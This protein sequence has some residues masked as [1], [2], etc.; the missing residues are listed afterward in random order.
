[1]TGALAKD[2]GA[3][4]ARVVAAIVAAGVFAF[5]A[6]FVLSAYAPELRQGNDGG[7]HALSKS[8]VGF[9][10]IVR[11][12]EAD[13]VPVEISRVRASATAEGAIALV[14]ITLTPNGERGAVRAIR[15][16]RPMALVVLPKWS[17]QPHPRKPGWVW[18]SGLLPDSVVQKALGNATGSENLVIQR[19]ADRS[20]YVLLPHKKFVPGPLHSGPIRSPQTISGPDIHPFLV[21]AS[22]G[23]ILGFSRRAGCYILADPDLLN[24]Q[25]VRDLNTARTAVTILERLRVRPLPIKFDV[26]LH[27]LAGGR[28]LLKLAFSPPFLA[29]TL[30]AAAAAALAGWQAAMRWGPR[31]EPGR[32]VA[33]GKRALADNA[34][35]LIRLS[36]REHRM[37][38]RYAVVTEAALAREAAA[39]AGEPA[40]AWLDGL[41]RRRPELPLWSALRAEAR[42]ART[43]EALLATAKR[44]HEWRA[45][46]GR[47]H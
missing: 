38:D 8:A 22:G 9:A 42:A 24:T 12:L 31:A 3:F 7:A 23:V 40:A 18:R 27:G 29:V 16:K 36:G 26:T 20:S 10:G 19:G 15:N 30:C 4:S 1:M 44:I 41:G 2:D 32:A 5:A 46:V 28:S 6:Y 37:A 25:G 17:T 14:V 21:D 39:P 34:A 11:L 35:A 13:G 45:E 33:L 43:R 47:G